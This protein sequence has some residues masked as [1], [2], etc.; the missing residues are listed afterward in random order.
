MPLFD[1]LRLALLQVVH[2]VF[3]YGDGMEVD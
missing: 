3:D 2:F 1:D